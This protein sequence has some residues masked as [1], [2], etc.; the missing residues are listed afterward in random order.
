MR[1]TAC[2][3]AALLL[4]GCASKPPAAPRRLA[5]VIGNG[6]YEGSAALKNPAN[7][8]A[9]MCK[10]LQRLR[11]ETMCHTNVAD[12]AGFEALVRAYVARLGPNTVG[13]VHYSGH[14]VQV[15]GA[16]L[17]V[18]TA[19]APQRTAADTVAALYPVNELFER[20]R[21][22]AAPLHIVV[23]D[24]CRTDLFA[25]TRTTA[26]RGSEALQRTLR[27]LPGAQQELAP[28][29]H[30]PPNTRVLYA[31]GAGE[32]AYDGRGSH[33]PLTQ[34]VLAHLF[35]PNLPLE[36]FFQRVTRDVVATTQ[37]EFKKPMTPYTY[38]SPRVRFCF[39][40]CPGDDPGV[41]PT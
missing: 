37:A 3:I 2:L 24:A 12:R 5:L 14:G 22:T 4:A 6:A 27:T 18:P 9:A 20:L 28:M 36:E 31:T 21:G 41:S 16:N 15:R 23:L 39:A 8:A 30:V 1:T 26:S 32:A 35:T 19:L 29:P 17:L 10:A 25:D 40:G 13:L 33:G 7:D 34:Q 38:G 11:F